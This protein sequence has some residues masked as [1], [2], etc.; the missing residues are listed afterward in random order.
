LRTP[1]ANASTK[2]ADAGAQHCSPGPSLGLLELLAVKAARA[3][4]RRN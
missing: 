1:P 4:L 2:P 3:V